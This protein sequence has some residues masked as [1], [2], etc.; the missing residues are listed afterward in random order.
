MLVRWNA[1][2]ARGRIFAFG[3]LV[4]IMALLALGSFAQRD[5][6]VALFAAP[7]RSEQVGEVVER[8]AEWNALSSRLPIT[9]AS[10]SRV[11][12]NS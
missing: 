11:A 7:L 10:M 9:Y 4:V 1:L 3:G 6:R 8:L 12:T 5:T 2:D